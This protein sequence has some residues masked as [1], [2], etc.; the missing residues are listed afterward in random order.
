VGPGGTGETAL[1]IRRCASYSETML[2]RAQTRMLPVVNKAG[3]HAPMVA[4]CCNACRT[5]VT[6]NVI[7]L[8]F[9][10]GAAVAAVFVAFF[11]RLRR[12]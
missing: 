3:D 10:A 12:A 11:R 6:T 1:C 5:C 2:E 7:G 4:V 9:A 8:V